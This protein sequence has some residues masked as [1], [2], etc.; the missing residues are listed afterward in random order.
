ME[1]E[2]IVK[3]LADHDGNRTHAAKA[4]GLSRRTLLYKIKRYRL[5]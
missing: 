2:L 4:L 5:V 3:T 1:R